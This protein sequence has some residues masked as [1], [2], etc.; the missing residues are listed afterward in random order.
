[1]TFIAPALPAEIGGAGTAQLADRHD[2]MLPYAHTVLA[3]RDAAAS[4]GSLATFGKVVVEM[5]P[6]GD[7][8]SRAAEWWTFWNEWSSV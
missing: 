4:R 8:P 6:A 5:A 7:G 3:A 1:M 2:P